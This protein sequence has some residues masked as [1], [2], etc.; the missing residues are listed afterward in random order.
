MACRAR[1]LPLIQN[2]EEQGYVKGGARPALQ[3]VDRVKDER[4]SDREI[5]TQYSANVKRY[6][7]I[8]AQ[9]HRHQPVRGNRRRKSDVYSSSSRMIAISARELVRILGP[10]VP[11]PDEV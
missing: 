11:A 2:L 5:A 10:H 4:R 6:R 8:P 7:S 9:A 3:P 1:K